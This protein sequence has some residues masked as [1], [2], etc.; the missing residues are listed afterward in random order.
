MQ[1]TN[2]ILFEVALRRDDLATSTHYSV[3][4]S[5][6]HEVHRATKALQVDATPRVTGVHCCHSKHVADA[7]ALLCRLG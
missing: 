2:H 7:Q 4:N 6:R 3:L 5:F 1:H